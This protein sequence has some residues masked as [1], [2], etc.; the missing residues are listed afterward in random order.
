MYVG[1]WSSDVCSSDLGNV[2]T[3]SVRRTKPE[4]DADLMLA[5][6]RV[7]ASGFVR[8][9]DPVLTL[10]LAGRPR[11]QAASLAVE[12]G[13]APCRGSACV[14]VAGWMTAARETAC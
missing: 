11:L 9:T 3:G 12:I 1:D 7:L 5:D 8:L 13:R 6:G 14:G 10:P 2:S 4:I